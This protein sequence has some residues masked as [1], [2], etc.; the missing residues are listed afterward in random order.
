M[1][2][3]VSKPP[4]A[5]ARVALWIIAL[6]LVAF[7]IVWPLIAGM[8]AANDDLK[9]LR[10][11][12]YSG[13]LSQNLREGWL[14]ATNFRPLEN[15][16]A[17]LC[18]AQTLECRRV[19]L[20]QT[21]GL[22][23]LVIGVAK[24]L[25]R[26]IPDHYGIA[27]PLMIVWLA[28]S[29]ATTISLWQMDTGSQTWSAALG[30]WTGLLAWNAITAAR[31]GKRI[32]PHLLGLTLLTA[33]AVNVKETG[34]GWSA[35][36]GVAVMLAIAL[37]WKC[38]RRGAARSL[39]L[40]LPV[41]ILPALH[42]LYR[43][44]FTGLASA[45][46]AGAASD[47]RYQVGL[48]AN[49]LHNAWLSLLGLF[50]NGPL[51]LINDDAA[52]L[53]LKLLPLA[54]LLASF[55]AVAAAA[56]LAAL[57]HQPPA[58]MRLRAVLLAALA[59]LLSISVTLPMGSVSEL[60]GMGANAASGLLVVVALLGLW[61]PAQ[62]DE[63]GLC[64]AI[65][66]MCGVVLLLAGLYGV[67]SRAYHFRL[68]WMYARQLNRIVLDHQR[69]LPPVSAANPASPAV[70]YFAQ[71]CY[72]G[73]VHNAYVVPPYVAIGMEQTMEWMNRVDAQRPVV[74]TDDPFVILEEHDLRV[75][76][77]ALPRRGHW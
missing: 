76:C 31:D 63:R 62:S 7:L 66:I 25:R 48:G 4:V 50:A 2:S 51:H 40:L 36:I 1:T 30:V 49:I 33:L 56:A 67:A 3:A 46:H 71:P 77:A 68:T 5:A 10:S 55:I 43:L 11:E 32:W 64:R 27:L 23:A 15:I 59:G 21:A 57:H 60:Y 58:G 26:L 37:R 6:L 8:A 42:L 28:V 75:D 65:A 41:A 53:L 52:P 74:F 38:D 29:P 44:K 69:S 22:I 54:S 16:A 70:I 12:Q 35:G 72:N 14:H 34:Y 17:A 20:I 39:W 9:F 13:T 19:M 61:H 24:L 45:M 47:E 18:D 73:L